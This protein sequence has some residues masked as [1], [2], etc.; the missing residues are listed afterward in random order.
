[1]S[2]WTSPLDLV[3]EG[4]DFARSRV[5]ARAEREA[6]NSGA[7][8]ASRRARAYARGDFDGVVDEGEAASVV[9]AVVVAAKD[10]AELDTVAGKL[11]PLLADVTQA[12]IVM[13]S[14]VVVESIK[15]KPAAATTH[16]P[17]RGS[18]SAVST[19]IV[20]R[21]GAFFSIFQNLQEFILFS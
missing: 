13:G 4:V 10:T 11:Q 15:S 7:Y 9:I 16:H 14:S 20:M 18:F 3:D 8:E 17:F 1:M 21:N 5:D 19:P 6:A 2:A 12:A